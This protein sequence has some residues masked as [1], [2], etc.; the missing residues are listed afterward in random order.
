MKSY[1]TLTASYVRRFLFDIL[2]YIDESGGPTQFVR[3]KEGKKIPYE[4]RKIDSLG[5]KQEE[6]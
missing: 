3:S 1:V 6:V 2:N 4:I 5:D